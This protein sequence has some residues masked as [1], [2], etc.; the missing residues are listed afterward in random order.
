MRRLTG[1]PANDPETKRANGLVRRLDRLQRR[2]AAVRFVNAV[3][4][5]FA[6]DQAGNL[7]SLLAYYAFAFYFALCTVGIKNFPVPA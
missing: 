1:E 2:S 6:D 3:L 4:R 7:A 5:K